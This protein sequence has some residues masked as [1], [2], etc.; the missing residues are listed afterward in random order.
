MGDKDRG[1]EGWRVEMDREEEGPSPESCRTGF[2]GPWS[3]L[4]T[5]KFRPPCHCSHT[6]PHPG[7]L[8]DASAWGRGGQSSGDARPTQT[9]GE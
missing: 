6:D 8:E 3:L 2:R 4:L 1:A 5:V 7:A 9:P